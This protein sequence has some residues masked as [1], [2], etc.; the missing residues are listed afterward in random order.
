MVQRVGRGR[1]VLR[2]ACGGVVLR[3]EW[4]RGAAAGVR[5]GWGH[6]VRARFVAGSAGEF[7]ASQP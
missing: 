3:E 2:V 1:V 5:A 4:R 6:G 7:P